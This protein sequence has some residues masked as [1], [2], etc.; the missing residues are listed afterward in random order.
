M[1]CQLSCTEQFES[2][3]EPLILC[4]IN[5][6]FINS[7]YFSMNLEF[8]WKKK[9]FVLNSSTEF[10]FWL[11]NFVKSTEK[12]WNFSKIPQILMSVNI[13]PKL[14]FQ[15]FITN[16]KLLQHNP[17]DQQWHNLSFFWIN[18]PCNMASR[19]MAAIKNPLQPSKEANDLD[20]KRMPYR[21]AMSSPL[22]AVLSIAVGI[23]WSLGFGLGGLHLM[24]DEWMQYNAVTRGYFT[25]TPVRFRHTR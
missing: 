20:E 14:Q 12:N 13:L 11:T 10:F 9:N 7:N 15:P 3:R 21:W 22:V 16:N 23:S 2:A 18:S 25:M 4:N 8:K 17:L 24:G 19:F 5:S 6:H 1:S